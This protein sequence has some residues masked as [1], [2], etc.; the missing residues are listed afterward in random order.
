MLR[1]ICAA[2]LPALSRR[3]HDTRGPP[4]AQDRHGFTIVGLAGSLSLALGP[5]LRS[6]PF[7]LCN[8]LQLF[9]R[10][11]EGGAG[12]R[13]ARHRAHPLIAWN[14][15]D[16]GPHWSDA[17]NA[18]PPL[19]QSAFRPSPYVWLPIKQIFWPSGRALS[20]AGFQMSARRTSTSA[21]AA[22]G[23]K[24]R[25]GGTLIAS[26][27]RPPRAAGSEQRRS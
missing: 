25:A 17:K 5:K 14:D 23:M 13:I 19:R 1:Q 2:L 4:P 21:C 20:R 7:A 3:L 26:E 11:G 24:V 8:C 10:Q 9:C 15:Q 16:E 27:P 18:M 22:C 12:F 6:R